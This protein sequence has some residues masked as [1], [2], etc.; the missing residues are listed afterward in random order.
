MKTGLSTLEK[1]QAWKVYIYEESFPGELTLTRWK[2]D[3]TNVLH[4]PE[5]VR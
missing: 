2:V 3:G 5:E 1:K 4:H